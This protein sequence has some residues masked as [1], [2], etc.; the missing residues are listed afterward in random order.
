MQQNIASDQQS[1]QRNIIERSAVRTST[2]VKR[3]KATVEP[4]SYRRARGGDS[5]RNPLRNASAGHRLRVAP[6]TSA[7][8]TI[9]ML[10]L[11]TAHYKHRSGGLTVLTSS[12]TNRRM[13]SVSLRI[14]TAAPDDVPGWRS[15]L[16]PAET[17]TT[18][19]SA[20]AAPFA[21]L[22]VLPRERMSGRVCPA[23][24]AAHRTRALAMVLDRLNV[25]GHEIYGG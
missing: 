11:I 21:L 25:A 24:N 19:T 18:I 2:W 16:V 4:R 8:R 15:C 20:E 10:E 14:N 5:G 12:S 17:T 1:K 22:R 13:A 6:W 3:R 7:D 23:G 9:T